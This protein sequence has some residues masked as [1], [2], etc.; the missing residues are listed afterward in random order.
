MGEFLLSVLGG[1][2]S[3]G[4][5]KLVL[6]QGSSLLPGVSGPGPKPA[7]ELRIPKPSVTLVAV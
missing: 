2:D 5:W 7:N 3:T 6:S 4:G 1:W